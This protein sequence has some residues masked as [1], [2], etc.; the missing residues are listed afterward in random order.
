[1]ARLELVVSARQDG[2]TVRSLLKGELG[3][4]TTRWLS[5]TRQSGLPR[6]SQSLWRWRSAMRTAIC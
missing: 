3:L 5:W 2:R 4:S 1:M 6:W